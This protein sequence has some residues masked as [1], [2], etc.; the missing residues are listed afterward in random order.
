MTFSG[1]HDGGQHP[2]KRANQGCLR[3]SKRPA[4]KVEGEVGMVEWEGV[5]KRCFG[6][7]LVGLGCGN[8]D[9]S[10]V[11]AG[12]GFFIC[13]VPARRAMTRENWGRGTPERTGQTMRWTG[14]VDG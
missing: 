11:S 3:L 1:S 14:G 2:L 5:E 7:I 4:D 6:A 12:R 13:L 10:F 8:C 9:G